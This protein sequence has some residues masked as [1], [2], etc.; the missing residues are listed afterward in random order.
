MRFLADEKLV[1]KDSNSDIVCLLALNL[2]NIVNQ[3]VYE[4]KQIWEDL[5]SFDIFLKI[6]TLKQSNI[7]PAYSAIASLVDD[8]QIEC[9]KDIDFVCEFLCDLLK[10]WQEEFHKDGIQRSKRQYLF[11]GKPVEI[12]ICEVT[13]ENNVTWGI[14]EIL[15]NLYKLSI[16]QK[17]KESIYFKNGIKNCLDDLIQASISF[18]KYLRKEYF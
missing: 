7:L 12:E 18:F 11:E 13:D 3:T 8:T 9:R 16:S 17:L 2:A 1:K 10:K 5:N 15:N 14:K 6:A 4:Y